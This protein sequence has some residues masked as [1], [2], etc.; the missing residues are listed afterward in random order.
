[1]KIGDL[2]IDPTGEHKGIGIIKDV[3]EGSDYYHLW[4][5]WLY[6]ERPYSTGCRATDVEVIN[7]NG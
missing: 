5:L 1:M 3:N 4:I 2:V 7:E 6:G